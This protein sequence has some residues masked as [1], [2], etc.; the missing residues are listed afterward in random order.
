MTQIEI[1]KLAHE[2]G[3]HVA[4]DVN[5]MPVIGLEYA[6]KFAN[7]ATQYEREACAEHYLNI[8]R[9]TVRE[10][11]K[12]EREACAKLCEAERRLGIDDERAYYGDLMAAAIR[13]RGQA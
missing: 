9:T 2:A 3:L 12:R 10:A 1:I 8:M 11:V 13:A 7:L 6:E 4:T 5:W